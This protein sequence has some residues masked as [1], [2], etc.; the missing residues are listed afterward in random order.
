MPAIPNLASGSANPATSASALWAYIKPA[1][2]HIVKSP[3][4]DPNGKAPAIDVVLYSGIHSACYNYFTAQSEAASVGAS[5]RGKAPANGS[6]IYENLDRYFQEVCQ[7]IAL[8]VPDDDSTLVHYLI[9]AFNRFSAGAQSANRLLN[10]I[11]RHY[12]K[13]AV[14]EDR[15]WLRLNDVLESVVKNITIEDTRE[16]ISTRLKEK[17]AE[18]LKKWGYSEGDSGERLA[19]AEACSEAA[20]GPD[21]IVPVVSLAHRRFRIEVFEPL[22]LAPKTKGTSKAKH[23]IPKAVSTAAPYRPKGRLARAVQAVMTAD[24]IEESERLQLITRLGHA[25]QTV[26]VR[27]DHALR[28]RI[29]KYIASPESRPQKRNGSESS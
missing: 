6:D 7:E 10:Y 16:K 18:E 4:N 25:L 29:D 27:P 12:V 21:R 20:S 3:S 28:K 24:D 13:R 1:L 9:P 26:G 8:G 19:Y 23:R 22:L 15:G 14:D 17:R 2:D 11:N 5:S